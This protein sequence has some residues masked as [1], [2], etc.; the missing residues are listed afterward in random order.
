L[1]WIGLEMAV[2]AVR[3]SSKTAVR[4]LASAGILI[5]AAVSSVQAQTISDSH[6]PWPH[7]QFMLE[8]GKYLA[9][10]PLDGRIGAWN[11]GIIG[12]YQGGEVVN[13]DGL[14]NDDIFPYAASN[15]LPEYLSSHNI[16][17]I[18]D[19][20]NMF[21]YSFIRMRGGFNDISF[22]ESLQPIR[23]FGGAEYSWKNL[24]LYKI[25]APGEE[26]TLR[27]WKS[28][29]PRHSPLRDRFYPLDTGAG[30]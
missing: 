25:A 6:S 10:N 8:A 21:F 2:E 9:A 24:T 17:Y 15:R 1:L 26:T 13:I 7:Q 23:H 3:A 29:R 30:G 18:I 4:R 16:R 27:V 22:L 12:Y 20:D 5:L 14:V 19:F 11:A 28:L